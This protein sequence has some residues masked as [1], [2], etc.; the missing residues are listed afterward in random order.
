MCIVIDTN[1]LS[2]VF[3]ESNHLHHL[4]RPVLEWVMTGR[5]FIVYGG[6]TYIA[7]LAKVASVL[8]LFVEFERARRV[9]KIRNDLVDNHEIAVRKLE[10]D[11]SFNDPH[12]VAILRASGCRLVCTSDK[13]SHPFLKRRALYLKRQRPPMIFSGHKSHANLLNNRNIVESLVPR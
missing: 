8:R 10:P 3:S 12:I 5:G 13:K 4:F 7:E 9:T 2:P 6:S 11:P 1:T